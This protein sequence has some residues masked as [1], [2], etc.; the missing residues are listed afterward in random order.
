MDIHFLRHEKHKRGHACWY[1]K[2]QTYHSHVE[3]SKINNTRRAG[4]YSIRG[5]AN[6]TRKKEI[7][8]FGLPQAT[9]TSIVNYHPTCIFAVPSKAPHGTH[10]SSSL[11]TGLCA[12]F[13]I[14]L[15]CTNVHTRANGI[16]NGQFIYVGPLEGTRV[17][18]Y[19]HVPSLNACA[20]FDESCTS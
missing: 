15:K 5:T 18:I 11:S 6:Q 20:F 17:S 7:F 1:P 12:E 8:H 10:A 14:A 13:A 3:W 2:E 4:Q 16:T 9:Q 19:L